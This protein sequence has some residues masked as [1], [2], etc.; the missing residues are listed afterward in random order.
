MRQYSLIAASIGCLV[1]AS[2]AQAHPGHGE[3]GNDFSLVHYATEPMHLGVG[4]CLLLASIAVMKLIGTSRLW[5]QRKAAG[6]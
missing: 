6:R 4:F 1:S 5:H 2:V 3:P